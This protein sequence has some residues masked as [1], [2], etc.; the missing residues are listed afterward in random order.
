[1]TSMPRRDHMALNFSFY[2][3]LI[4]SH[5]KDVGWRGIGE[6]VILHIIHVPLSRHSEQGLCK[7]IKLS[8]IVSYLLHLLVMLVMIFG[9]NII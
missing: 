4:L 8:S 2:P 7:S 3:G 1:M 5:R 6:G 9:E